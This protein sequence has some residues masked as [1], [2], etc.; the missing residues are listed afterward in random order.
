MKTYQD[1]NSPLYAG[2]PFMEI[3]GEGFT[4]PCRAE[5]KLDGEFQYVIKQKGKLYLANKQEHGRIRIE[6]PVLNEIEDKIP[7][8]S[9]F[10]AELVWGGGKDFYDFARHKLDPN[11]GLGFF[12]CLKY[13]GHQLWGNLTYAATRDFLEQQK[14]Y[15][16]N[17]VLIPSV[18]VADQQELDDLYQLVVDG[19]YEGIVAKTPES[20]YVNGVTHEWTK[21]KNIA[22]ND[23]AI[24]GF[25][26][27]TKR[28]K[29]LSVLVGYR[30]NGTIRRLTYVGGGFTLE[31]KNDL[32]GV[33][34]DTIIARNGDEY[35]VDPQIVITVKHY[36]VIRND[37]GEVH[38]LRHPQFKSIRL[39]K[40]IDEIDTL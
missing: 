20:K 6:M 23:F 25:Q 35:L 4:F 14:F 30:L 9:V 26:S 13:S 29:L 19:G 33:L 28:A 18:I 24:I 37:S 27:G 16:P 17:A 39:D 5:I 10:L 40:T 34:K 3:E 7:D 31:Q 15:T 2:L 8:D 12:S 38:S 22:D 36:G 11:C 1:K 21:R 32:L